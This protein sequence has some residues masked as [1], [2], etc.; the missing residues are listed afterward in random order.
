MQIALA[1]NLSEGK[2]LRAVR[3]ALHANG[4]VSDG[5][6]GEK[7]I[8]ME[9]F[10]RPSSTIGE[11]DNQ[12]RLIVVGDRPYERDPFNGDWHSELSV[13]A[14]QNV[15][16]TGTRPIVL[17]EGG[18]EMPSFLFPAI[19]PDNERIAFCN[20]VDFQISADAAT[21]RL[22]EKL[23]L[24]VPRDDII[25]AEALLI[26][27]EWSIGLLHD[28]AKAGNATTAK[29]LRELDPSLP[30]SAAATLAV[31]TRKDVLGLRECL[32]SDTHN[33]LVK[34]HLPGGLSLLHIA[35]CVPGSSALVDLL[36]D[37][38]LS[39]N[40]RS[41]IGDTP[42]YYAA[43]SEEEMAALLL[44][45]GA[46]PTNVSLEGTS[47]LAVAAWL[48]YDKLAERA[49][50]AG[51][52]AFITDKD[53]G[54]PLVW[55]SQAGHAKIVRKITSR[56]P[57][58]IDVPTGEYGLG[59]NDPEFS[60]DAPNVPAIVRYRRRRIAKGQG[61]GRTALIVAIGASQ[62]AIIDLLLELGADP[63]R[64]DRQGQ[65]P[66]HYL[67]TAESDVTEHLLRKLAKAGAD[68]DARDGDGATPLSYA[69][70]GNR[71]N[72]V[73]YLLA[74]R[75]NPELK[76]AEGFTP[77]HLAA[78]FGKTEIIRLLA[79]KADIEARD[80][81]GFTPLHLGI[82]FDDVPMRQTLTLRPGMGA[83][84]FHCF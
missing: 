67:A 70:L 52:S 72:L 50:D 40:E 9:M 56:F 27:S 6:R 76:N 21:D 30:E 54:H 1:H 4:F 36:L 44:D 24:R 39:P 10:V 68:V 57:G 75:A 12:A 51:T 13:G 18:G 38:G 28:L 5:D 60:P 61:L 29:A 32:E 69:V 49:L 2:V 42:L 78:S 16:K 77:L 73:R 66:L 41:N 59:K 20:V 46:D 64:G 53:G 84:L 80:S 43:W 79:E 7:S 55:A 15:Y 35:A 71:S 48:G 11:I 14:A 74:A 83:G 63:N 65:S 34:F 45:R 37:H 25:M 62:T 82:F 81:K 19:V 22:L 8:G 23:G 3:E 26:Q 47:L 17:R 58:Q 31:I 33:E